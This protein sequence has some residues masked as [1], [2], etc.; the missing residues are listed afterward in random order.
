MLCNNTKV[1]K[2][3]GEKKMFKE[4]I[5]KMEEY[6][7]ENAAEIKNI[8]FEKVFMKTQEIK[9]FLVEKHSLMT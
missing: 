4:M 9:I 7:A 8:H 5:K 6:A 3:D 1:I 2:K